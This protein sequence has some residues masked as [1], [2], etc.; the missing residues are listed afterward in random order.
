MIKKKNK[1]FWV[2]VGILALC[3]FLSNLHGRMNM[4][5]VLDK[6]VKSHQDELASKDK[7]I[8]GKTQELKMLE[9]RYQTV[10]KKLKGLQQQMDNIK[11]PTSNEE[12]RRRYE[13]MGFSPI[14]NK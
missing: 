13:K 1:W 6:M 4:K 14:P 7:A 3:V 11:P 8:E 12:M 9:Q 5:S 10:I 2:V